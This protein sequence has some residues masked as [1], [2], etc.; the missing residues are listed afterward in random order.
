MIIA[1]PL[2]LGWISFL[3]YGIVLLRAS[4]HR[5]TRITLITLFFA[6]IVFSAFM[7]WYMDYDKIDCYMKASDQSQCTVDNNWEY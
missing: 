1:I 7:M 5:K 3:I 6:P 2:F 4:K